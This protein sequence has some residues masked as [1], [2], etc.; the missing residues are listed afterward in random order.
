MDEIPP[1][2]LY[3]STYTLY[4]LSPLF[5]G[6]TPLL[7][8]TALKTHARRLR[9]MLKGDTLRGVHVGALE[10]NL[11]NAGSLEDCTWDLLGDEEAWATTHRRTPDEEEENQGTINA[12]EVTADNARGVQVRLHYDKATHTALLL[13]DPTVDFT[14]PG[15]T[16]LPL[17]LVRM[18]AALRDTFLHY[19][20]A[21]F[22]TCIS[23]MRPRSPFLTTSLERLLARVKAA[24]ESSQ[25][26]PSPVKPVQIQLSFPGVAPLLRNIDITIA[27][28]DVLGLVS[29]GKLL[30]ETPHPVLGTDSAVTGPFTRAL[31]VYLA[32]HLALAL[33]HPG[34]EVSRVACGAFALSSDGKIK[35]FPPQPQSSSGSDDARNI[36]HTLSTSQLA[37]RDFYSSL[38]QETGRRP[39]LAVTADAGGNGK[40]AIDLVDEVAATK[41]KR[42]R[43]QSSADEVGGL[44]RMQ[45]PADP[46][47]PYELHDPARREA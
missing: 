47:P 34:V 16:S 12:S 24:A 27:S 26:L 21:N 45:T 8:G 43:D 32:T 42:Q 1:Y 35:L 33:D 36:D 17:L 39:L 4:R 37:M 10:N 19:L 18:P 46:P 40:R 7:T 44:L 30:G 2:P 23:P 38:L 3:G 9:D 15:F 29:R 5:H 31:Q 28:D 6:Q 41:A 11:S 22:D 25:D 13:R 20:T 14:T